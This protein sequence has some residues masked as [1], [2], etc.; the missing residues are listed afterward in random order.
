MTPYAFPVVWCANCNA[1]RAVFPDGRGFPPDIA[2]RKLAKSCREHGCK[3]D[4][5][6]MAGVS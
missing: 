2:K 6:Y 5:Q 4:P 3:C 1:V